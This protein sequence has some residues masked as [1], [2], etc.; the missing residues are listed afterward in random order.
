MQATDVTQSVSARVAH[1]QALS[2]A[3][4]HEGR[5]RRERET[6]GDVIRRVLICLQAVQCGYVRAARIKARSKNLTS[7]VV[8]SGST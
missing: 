2:P 1:E 8:I 5:T 7:T 3:D 4:W 6:S